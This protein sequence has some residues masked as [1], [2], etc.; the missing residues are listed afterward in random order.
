MA[1]LDEIKDLLTTILTRQT[2]AGLMLAAVEKQGQRNADAYKTIANDIMEINQNLKVVA[3]RLDSF[4]PE[5]KVNTTQVRFIKKTVT[6]LEEV[7]GEDH[8]M[9]AA[10]HTRVLGEAAFTRQ[11]MKTLEDEIEEIN[12]ERAVAGQ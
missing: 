8:D 11:K 9:L 7:Q 5:L 3:A 1:D 2:N 4:E 10:L 6:K 12:G